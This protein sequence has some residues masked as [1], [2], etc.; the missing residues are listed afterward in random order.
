MSEQQAQTEA[1]IKAT[2]KQRR[3]LEKRRKEALEQ[4]RTGGKEGNE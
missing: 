2:E 1:D 3:E 4:A